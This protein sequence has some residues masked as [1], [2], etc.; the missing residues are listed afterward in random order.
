MHAAQWTMIQFNPIL[1]T[2]GGQ[3]FDASGKCTVNNEAG[4][5]AM[6]ARASIARQYGAE[7][8]ADSIATNPLPQMDWLKERCSMFWCH[9]IPPAAIKSQNQKMLAR[10]TTGR[11]SIPASR[12][13][14]ASPRPTG[15]TSS[16]TRERRR[17]SRRLCTTSTSSS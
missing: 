3:W 13:A 2:H 8:P 17:T 16:S 4:V 15:S 6:T 1:I 12:P 7:D 11:S 5:K 14:R 9:P 10:A